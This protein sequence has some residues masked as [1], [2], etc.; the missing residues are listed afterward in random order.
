MIKAEDLAVYG[1]L[2]RCIH[3]FS[4]LGTLFTSPTQDTLASGTMERYIEHVYL[5]RRG[6]GI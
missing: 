4:N 1:N 6:P 3:A 2:L 5:Y